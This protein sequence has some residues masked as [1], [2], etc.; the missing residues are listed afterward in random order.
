MMSQLSTNWWEIWSLKVCATKKT[1]RSTLQIHRCITTR[2]VVS[3]YIQSTGFNVVCCCRKSRALQR[4]QKT[5]R[6][7]R[8]NVASSLLACLFTHYRIVLII[9]FF[10]TYRWCYLRN[11]DVI[12]TSLKNAVFER[13]KGIQNSFRLVASKFAGFK[14]SWL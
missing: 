9:Y 3:Y 5:R 8:E 7:L 2:R 13:R 12:M 4:G 1:Y 10:N 11:G 6:E 14:S